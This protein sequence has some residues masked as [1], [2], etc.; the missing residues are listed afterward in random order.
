MTNIYRFISKTRT[1]IRPENI[2]PNFL[3]YLPTPNWPIDILMVRE[4]FDTTV[5]ECACGDGR[6]SKRISSWG[7]KV[8]SSDLIDRGFGKIGIDF[9]T[10]RPFASC[11]IT[12][13]PFK[14]AQ[15]FIER[16]IEI[17]SINKFAFLLRSMYV[18]SKKRRHIFEINPP[19]KII[20]IADRVQFNGS[21]KPGGAFAMSWFIWDKNYKGPTTYEWAW[22]KDL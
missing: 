8:I 10:A 18:E 21:E 20:C 11:I 5:W 7:Y 3:D 16:C 14:K 6:M 1:K 9:L 22:F 19:K 12:N 2:I 17:E 4:K 13:P 15:Q